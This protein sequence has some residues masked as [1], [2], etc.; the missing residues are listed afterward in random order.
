MVKV[1]KISPTHSY[2]NVIQD[3]MIT[4]NA[5]KKISKSLCILQYKWQFWVKFDENR[6]WDFHGLNISNP[7]YNLRQP[8][9]TEFGLQIASFRI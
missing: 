4:Y 5:K 1:S 2:T 7:N 6:P 3:P 8:I 9:S